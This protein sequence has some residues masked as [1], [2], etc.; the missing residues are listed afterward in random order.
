MNPKEEKEKGKKIVRGQI[1]HKVHLFLFVVVC[2][3]VCLSGK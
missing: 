1:D 3:L 2:L